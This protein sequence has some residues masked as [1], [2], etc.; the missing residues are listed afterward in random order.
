MK[1]LSNN[2]VKK[3]R[4]LKDSFNRRID[5]LRVSITDKC[6]LKCVYCTP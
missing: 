3:T 2:S 6:N 4:S 1:Q 5:Y